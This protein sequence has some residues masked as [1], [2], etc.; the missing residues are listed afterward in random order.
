[1]RS[2]PLQP[3]TPAP[4]FIGQG[5]VVAGTGLLKRY[6]RRSAYSRQPGG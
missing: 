3:L 2:T 6:S 1:M 4:I 5:F